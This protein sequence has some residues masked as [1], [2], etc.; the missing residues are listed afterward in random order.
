MLTVRSES[1]Q[2]LANGRKRK[3]RV[4]DK[5]RLHGSFI[6]LLGSTI[7]RVVFSDESGVGGDDQ[8]LTVVTA[9]LLNLDNQWD[10]IRRE[11]EFTRVATPRKLLS[12]EHLPQG[13]FKGSLLFKGL[14]NKVN[15]VRP[16]KAAEILCR[17]LLLVPKHSIHIFHGAVDRAGAKNFARRH[18]LTNLTD[19]EQAFS[20]C[21]GQL[22]NFAYAF[23]PKEKVLWIADRNKYENLIKE[24]LNFHRLIQVADLTDHLSDKYAEEKGLA[25]W[26]R[27]I[28]LLDDP[29]S[30]SPIVDTVYFGNSHESLALQLAD[31]CCTV[32]SEYLQETDEGKDFYG[33]IQSLVKSHGQPILYSPKWGGKNVE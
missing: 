22:A 33:I 1:R 12:R 24:G 11:L 19:A 16:S 28:R 30:A 23:L 31:V 7:V 27:G 20:E 9:I 4:G 14:R 3:Q 17:I 25:S 26:G 18:T 10:P 32:V 2:N 8:P 6:G 5:A 21:L 13:E 29:E 15:R